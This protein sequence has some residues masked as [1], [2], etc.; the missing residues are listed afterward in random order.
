[1]STTLVILKFLRK[2]EFCPF[3]ACCVIEKKMLQ[4][5]CDLRSIH[6]LFRFKVKVVSSLIMFLDLKHFFPSKLRREWIRRSKKAPWHTANPCGKN[7][8]CS[9][10]YRHAVW[11]HC[12]GRTP[13]R[14]RGHCWG[15][16]QCG[17]AISHLTGRVWR[18]NSNHRRW[19]CGGI[20]TVLGDVPIKIHAWRRNHSCTHHPS[21]QAT[22]W[23]CF[24]LTLFSTPTQF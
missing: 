4:R 1:M 19:W 8:L 18:R 17:T 6:G 16:R 15:L 7:K 20:G 14:C 10:S 12:W 21:T 2:S 9:W 3:K 22:K 5:K 11:R 24:C 13:Q 23:V